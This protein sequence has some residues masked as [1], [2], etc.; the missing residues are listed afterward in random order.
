MSAYQAIATGSTNLSFPPIE[1]QVTGGG[2]SHTFWIGVWGDRSVLLTF[3][4]N[5]HFSVAQ[6]GCREVPSR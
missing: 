1:F 3:P 4:D 2:T 6:F 5:T